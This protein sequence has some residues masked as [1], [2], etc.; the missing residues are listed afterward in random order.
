MAKDKGT[1]RRFES[2]MPVELVIMG[3]DPDDRAR[4]DAGQELLK[5]IDLAFSRCS[6]RVLQALAIDLARVVI[7]DATLEDLRAQVIDLEEVIGL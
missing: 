2:D 7:K 5:R 1:V 3:D 6:R 4:Y